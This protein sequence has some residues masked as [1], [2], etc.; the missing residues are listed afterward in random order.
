MRGQVNALRAVDPGEYRLLA[1]TLLPCRYRMTFIASKGI[2]KVVF[3]EVYE[4]DKLAFELTLG[5]C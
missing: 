1:V 3:R 2:R 4:T 5:L